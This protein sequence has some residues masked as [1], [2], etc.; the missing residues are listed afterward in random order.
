MK[1]DPQRPPKILGKGKK[2]IKIYGKCV[3]ELKENELIRD[4]KR[5]LKSDPQRPPKI[6]E[7]GKKKSK[8]MEN[9]HRS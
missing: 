3:Y 9:G 5:S 4:T 6:L 1:S 8:Y 7:K 2:K